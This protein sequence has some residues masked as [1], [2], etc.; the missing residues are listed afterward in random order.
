MTSAAN[1]PVCKEQNIVVEVRGSSGSGSQTE[2]FWCLNCNTK[3]ITRA[4]KDRLIKWALE[5]WQK[6]E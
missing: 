2:G 1:C 5:N 6:I 4:E 3:W